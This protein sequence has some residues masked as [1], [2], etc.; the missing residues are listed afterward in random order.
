LLNQRTLRSRVSVAGVGLHSGRSVNLALIPAAPNTGVVF[1]RT[2]VRRVDG[3]PVEIA[4]HAD[5]VLET[6]L[7]TTLGRDSATVGTV[8]HLMAALA[9]L[10]IDNVRVE[11]D[12]PEVPILD[13]SAAPFVDLIRSAGGT[14]AQARPK[15]FLVIRR[16]VEVRDGDRLARLEPAPSFRLQCFIDFRHPLITDQRCEFVFSDVAFEAEIA[17]ARTFGFARD[18]DAMRARGLAR[19]GSL[20]NAVVIDDFSIQNPEGLRF[21]DEFVRHKVLDAIGDLALF[22]AP[23]VGRFVGYKSGHMLNTRLVSAVL[24]ERR[25]YEWQA[26]RNERDAVGAGLELPALGLGRLAAV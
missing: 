6:R 7:A 1:A 16:P 21:P 24:A 17:R 3:A 23:V 4:A 2:D 5:N 12:G 25:A 20:D 11:L 22:G 14:V 18:V 15:R 10:G 13:G 26:F 19:G 8:E 9:G